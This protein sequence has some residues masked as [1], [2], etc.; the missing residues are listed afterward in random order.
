MVRDLTRR[1]QWLRWCHVLLLHELGAV[2]DIDVRHRRKLHRK[3]LLSRATDTAAAPFVGEAAPPPARLGAFDC[4][5]PRG[6]D[7][8]T[9]DLDRLVACHHHLMLRCCKPAPDEPAHRAAFEAM[10][11]DK[12]RR[13]DADWITDEKF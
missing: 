9:D 13:V 4:V 5:P 6:R 12:E 8:D 11:V 7:P 1:R 3:P 10:P 2:Q